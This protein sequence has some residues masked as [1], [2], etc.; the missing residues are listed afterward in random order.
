MLPMM[1]CTLSRISCKA[2]CLSQQDAQKGQSQSIFCL[3]RRSARRHYRV[4][5]FRIALHNRKDGSWLN[6][7]QYAEELSNRSV[8]R[9]RLLMAHLLLELLLQQGHRWYL[10][11]HGAASLLH[12]WGIGHHLRLVL[13]QLGYT[14]YYAVDYFLQLHNFEQLN[15]ARKGLQAEQ[16]PQLLFRI[17]Q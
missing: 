15:V 13:D 4:A 14:A 8:G 3:R 16:L 9:G 6:H 2:R 7:R 1:G 11:A 17:N 10:V 5:R 12:A